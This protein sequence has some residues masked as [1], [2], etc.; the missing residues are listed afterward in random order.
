[1][2][3]VGRDRIEYSLKGFTKHIPVHNNDIF[4][5]DGGSNRA[6]SAQRSFPVLDRWKDYQRIA[7]IGVNDDSALGVL[8]SARQ[9]GREQ[10]F[11]IAGHGGDDAIRHEINDPKSAY[12]ASSDI[13]M[14]QY[15]PRLIDLSLK[16]LSGK[17][18]P[19]ENFVQTG[20][21]SKA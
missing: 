9:L 6:D 11:A 12:I 13:G 5:I 2:T 17:R 20:C 7:V 21:V 10:H 18:V 8:D 16:M 4:Y 19:S 3:S 14:D 15:G 1:L